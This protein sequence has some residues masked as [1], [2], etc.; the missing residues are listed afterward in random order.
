MTDWPSG[1]PSSHRPI[2]LSS[3]YPIVL[4]SPT[5]HYPPTRRFI[6]P[7]SHIIVVPPSHILIVLSSH[8]SSSTVHRPFHRHPSTVHHP[9]SVVPSSHHPML[10][11][12]HLPLSHRLLIPPATVH[13]LIVLYRPII[14][15]TLYRSNSPIV[16]RFQPSF[17]HRPLSYH[18]P[19]I[20]KS[21]MVHITHSL[22]PNCLVQP[23]TSS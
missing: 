10:S 5:V 16:Y 2:V 12:S 9:P 19:S 20:V 11:P 3:H 6:V 15:L 23:M 1:L 22:L 8:R 17:I 13:R 4:S 7:S 18:P 21:S 14:S